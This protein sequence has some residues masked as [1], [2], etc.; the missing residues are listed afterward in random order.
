MNLDQL[1]RDA[2][3]Y[4]HAKHEARTMRRILWAILRKYGRV[5]I[6]HSDIEAI[7]PTDACEIKT[8]D[9]PASREWVIEAL[10]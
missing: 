2:A 10:P 5:R 8:T 9:D 4:Q 7:A 6:S 3:G 1:R